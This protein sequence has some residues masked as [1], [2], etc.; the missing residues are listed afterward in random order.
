L[1]GQSIFQPPSVKGWNGGRAW[2]NTSSLFVRQNLMVYLLT[3]LRPDVFPWQ[4]DLETFDAMPLVEHLRDEKGKL[5]AR[6]V[7]DWLLRFN[8]GDKPHLDRLTVLDDYLR[9]RGDRI[10]STRLIGLLCLITSMPEY[11]LC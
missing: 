10:D 3:G 9:S 4:T 8:L 2:I 6:V 7:F 11:Q 1:M 5:D